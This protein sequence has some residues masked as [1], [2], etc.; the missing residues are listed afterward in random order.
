MLPVTALDILN[1]CRRDPATGCMVWQGP[2]FK[3]GGYGRV[4]IAGKQR[5]AHRVLFE[6][7]NGPLPP[8]REVCHSCDNPPCCNPKHLSAGTHAQNMAEMKAKGRAKAPRGEDSPRAK[9][10]AATV[11]E[12]RRRALTDTVP[13]ISR[14]YGLNPSTVR[15]ILAGNTWRHA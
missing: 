8:G 6:I 15:D 13:R 10:D 9:V 3:W 4:I 1:R 5:R 12:I 11:K 2:R 7:L 14:F